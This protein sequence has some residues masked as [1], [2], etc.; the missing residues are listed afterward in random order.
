MY[1]EITK[2]L[3]SSGVSV[4]E[5]FLKEKIRDFSTKRHEA[6]SKEHSDQKTQDVILTALRQ[7]PIRYQ[8]HLDQDASIEEL[9]KHQK[10]ISRWASLVDFKDMQRAKK[11]SEIYVNLNVY[12]IPRQTHI[13]S[14]ETENLEPLLSAVASSDRNIVFLGHPGAG[15]TTTMK[16]IAGAQLTNDPVFEKH[17]F[18]ILVRLRQLDADYAG[19]DHLTNAVCNIFSCGVDVDWPEKL[20][21]EQH[22]FEK[23]LSKIRIGSLWRYL[24]QLSPL[25]IFDG[26]DEIA[27]P[28]MKSEVLAELRLIAQECFDLRLFLTS[29]TGEISTTLEHF[30]EF[31]LSPLK[32]KQ[33]EEFSSKWLGNAKQSE[34]FLKEVRSSPFFDTSIRPLSLAHLCAIYQRTG[35]V[36]DQPKSVYKKVVRLL[37]EE[38]DEQRGVVRGTK[39]ANFDTDRKFE[40]LSNLAYY[41]SVVLNRY[42]VSE[43][44]FFAAYKSLA[45]RFRLEPK[46][47]HEV[48]KEIEGHTGLLIR[49]GRDSFEFAHKSIQEYLAAEHIVRLPRPPVKF[50]ELKN[51][52]SELAVAVAISSSP[53]DF[54]AELVGSSFFSNGL[55]SS[56]YMSFLGRLCG[57]APDFEDA[58]RAFWCVIMTVSLI[59]SD[60]KSS[61]EIGNGNRKSRLSSELNLPKFEK[62]FSE[63]EWELLVAE[64]K[65]EVRITSDLNSATQFVACESSVKLRSRFSHVYRDF[66]MPPPGTVPRSEISKLFK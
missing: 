51:L 60:G 41:F 11:V 36:P 56:F 61:P 10:E 66:F 24:D 26:F 22:R 25:V 20:S 6:I 63:S 64:W 21:S 18:M 8:F 34:A 30:D 7:T 43:S 1:E 57:E 55:S 50:A 49:S 15:K 65:R 59:V 38:W 58:E 17:P 39:Y 29:R 28:K 33:V 14:S 45:R 35:R 9:V 31:E 5:N 13:D 46:E 54:Y 23:Y 42:V 48:T 62:M 19:T 44:D 47:M 16:K 12:L 52:S 4:A 3:I 27:S 32:W 37:L 40:F 53:G 2:K